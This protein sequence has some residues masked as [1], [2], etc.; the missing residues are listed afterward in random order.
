MEKVKPVKQDEN[1]EVR[2]KN[3]K[4]SSSQYLQVLKSDLEK[5]KTKVFQLAF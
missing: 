5:G 3:G 1:R 2:G 4:I